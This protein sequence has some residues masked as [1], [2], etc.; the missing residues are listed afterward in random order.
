MIELEKFLRI[1]KEHTRNSDNDYERFI[2][3][4]VKDI[5][6]T[7]KR[8]GK[9]SNKIYGIKV[10]L[11]NSSDE[12]KLIYKFYS[13]K[14]KEQ[15]EETTLVKILSSDELPVCIFEKLKDNNE[16]EIT[17]ELIEQQFA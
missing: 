13:S 2:T 17:D 8:L 4:L 15:W 6:Q 5:K 9:I 16:I 14:E 3:Y 12:I 11:N 7:T 10:Y 1:M